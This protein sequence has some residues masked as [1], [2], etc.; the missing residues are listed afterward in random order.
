LPH[1]ERSEKPHRETLKMYSYSGRLVTFESGA[2]S[3]NDVAVQLGRICRFAG[4]THIF[5]SVLCHS[6]VV[7]DL[8]PKHLQ[9]H[10]LLHDAGESVFSDI[11]S[12]FKSEL[13]HTQEEIVLKRIYLEAGIAWMNDTDREL[14]KRAD[15]RGFL[16]EVS[17]VAP[18]GYRNNFKR[19]PQ[20]ERLVS[21][22]LNRYTILDQVSPKG[23][24]VED[25]LRRCIGAKA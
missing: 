15:R 17:T 12:G 21:A 5:W 22:Y 14:V 7:A 16:G 8:L 3:I 10:G 4:G 25:F 11:P 9:I 19:D 1:P 20:A 2:P 23:R 18:L 6:M 24:A 13:I